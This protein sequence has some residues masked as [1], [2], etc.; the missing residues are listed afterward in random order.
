VG[1][2]FVAGLVVVVLLVAATRLRRRAIR[3]LLLSTG[4]QT[5]AISS[6]YRRGR[7]HPRIGLRYVDN[8]GKEQFAIKS[9]VSAGDAELLKKKA[10]VLYHPSRSDRSDYV[11]VGFGDHPSRWF[12]VEFSRNGVAHD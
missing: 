8:S 1:W 10:V 11:L 2:L 5:T 3:A 12:P 9:I 4:A 7:R 6:V